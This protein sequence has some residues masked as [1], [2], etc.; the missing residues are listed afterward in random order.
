[1]DGKGFTTS[2]SK[3]VNE[4]ITDCGVSLPFDPRK[5][6]QHQQIVKTKALWDTGATNSVITQELA[7]KLGLKSIRQIDSHHAGGT[8]RVNVYLVNIYLPNNAIV[9]YVQVSE[10]IETVGRFGILIGMDIIAMG[11]FAISNFGNRTTISFRVPSMQEI[12]L[13]KDCL[14][15][16]AAI[17]KN[18]VTKQNTIDPN[19]PRNNKC[20]CGSG[21]KYK[22]C[23]GK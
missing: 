2:Y 4:I 12:R 3:V 5:G 9:G 16:V 1:M 20:P 8:T 10:C 13:E 21:K 17:Q 11:D 14:P 19:T 23:H 15:V 22:H 18:T 7:T 6:E